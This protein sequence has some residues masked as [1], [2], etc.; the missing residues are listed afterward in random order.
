[1]G[2]RG[3]VGMYH[4][5][6]QVGKPG[7]GGNVHPAAW[8][9]HPIDIWVL[10]S[11]RADLSRAGIGRGPARQCWAQQS[12]EAPPPSLQEQQS[13]GSP[14]AGRVQGSR[15]RLPGCAALSMWE[16]SRG[17]CSAGLGAPG[18][19]ARGGFWGFFSP[20]FYGLCSACCVPTKNPAWPSRAHPQ[21]PS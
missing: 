8:S 10:N 5:P 3:L 11:F 9:L 21:T 19:E 7:T 1:M 15:L 4:L 17:R 12:L 16:Q 6:S 18:W 20:L 13:K 14:G 2:A